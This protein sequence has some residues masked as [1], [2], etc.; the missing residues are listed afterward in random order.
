MRRRYL[1][2]PLCGA[3]NKNDTLRSKSVTEVRF[4]LNGC[5]AKL[6]SWLWVCIIIKHL[7]S[8]RVGLEFDCLGI[9]LKFEKFCTGFTPEV[10]A[11]F[12]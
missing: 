6:Q 9:Q 10:D 5:P 2:V 11:M 7:I 3:M 1:F 12:V 8:H 4:S